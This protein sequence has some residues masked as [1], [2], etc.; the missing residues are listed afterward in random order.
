MQSS[1]CV[2]D[3]CIMRRC[4]LGMESRVHTEWGPEIL[5]R[6]NEHDGTLDQTLMMTSTSLN[7]P[8][9]DFNNVSQD[10]EN[11]RDLD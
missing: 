7:K 4:G 8:Y 11:L 2:I 9:E 10:R 1:C 6:T 5:G 3:P